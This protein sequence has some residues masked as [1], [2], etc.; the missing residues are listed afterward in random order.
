MFMTFLYKMASKPPSVVKFGYDEFEIISNRKWCA[1][2]N[3]RGEKITETRGTSSSFTKH[4]EWKHVAL[5]K[6]TRN[7]KVSGNGVSE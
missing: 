1:K 2:C 4:M 6:T 5:S 3:H 7:V